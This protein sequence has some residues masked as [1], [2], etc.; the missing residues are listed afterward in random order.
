MI[1][2]LVASWD[3]F[4]LTKLEMTLKKW[5]YDVFYTPIE[6]IDLIDMEY[7]VTEAWDRAVLSWICPLDWG[8]LLPDLK[9]FCNEW[10]GKKV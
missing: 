5:G 9:A 7:L 6:D 8:N 2:H 1:L 3:V 4:E 10:M